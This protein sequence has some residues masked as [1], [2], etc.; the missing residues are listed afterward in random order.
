MDDNSKNLRPS[1]MFYLVSRRQLG[2]VTGLSSTEIQFRV[3][4]HLKS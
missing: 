1:G 3:D 2:Y 4:G